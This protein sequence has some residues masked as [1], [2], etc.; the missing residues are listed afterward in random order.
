MVMLSLQCPKC[1]GSESI[2]KMDT[3]RLDINVINELTV[4][5][6]FKRIIQ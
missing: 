4:G 1:D 6:L 2:R 5:I 3:Q